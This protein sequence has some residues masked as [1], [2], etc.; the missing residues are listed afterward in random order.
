[1][2]YIFSILVVLSLFS[3][4]EET[5]PGPI[6]YFFDS[7]DSIQ[8]SLKVMDLYKNPLKNM[9]VLFYKTESDLINQSNPIFTST[10]NDSGIV[11]IKTLKY[12]KTYFIAQNDS[13]SNNGWTNGKAINYLFPEK[14]NDTLISHLRYTQKTNPN[15][16]VV[17]FKSG[18][19]GIG[20][21]YEGNN[22]LGQFDYWGYT[23]DPDC[24]SFGCLVLNLEAGDYQFLTK[25]NGS[26]KTTN[27][28]I[29]PNYCTK[30]KL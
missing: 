14:D 8:C 16:A 4:Q 5:N 17:V 29:A 9:P 20:E 6:S 2:K 26:T 24:S 25:I 21:I 13:F 1:M 11:K 28:F 18:D 27:L 19:Y 7:S 3:C 22:Y 30:L 12:K 23:A 15:G 10:S